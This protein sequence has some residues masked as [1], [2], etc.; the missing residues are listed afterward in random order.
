MKKPDQAANLIMKMMYFYMCLYYDGNEDNEYYHA[1]HVVGDPVDKESGPT[2]LSRC[3]STICLFVHAL[4]KPSLVR[5]TL[6]IDASDFSATFSC[7]AG[8]PWEA[9]SFSESKE[10]AG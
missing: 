4:F 6:C 9:S 10:R 7:C 5:T 2:F 8:T 1:K 3:S